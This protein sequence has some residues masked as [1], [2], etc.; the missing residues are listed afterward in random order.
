[1][2]ALTSG[3][4]E[5]SCSSNAMGSQKFIC[6][7][8]DTQRELQSGCADI[9]TRHCAAGVLQLLF[10]TDAST[11]EMST[12][13]AGRPDARIRVIGSRLSSSMQIFPSSVAAFVQSLDRL[14]SARIDRAA[15]APPTAC[16][17]RITSCTAHVLNYLEPCQKQVNN[18]STCE[19]VCVATS[20]LEAK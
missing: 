6:C 14:S 18:I 20:V 2:C 17:E 9:N 16:R 4:W 8:A 3:S 12:A 15:C 19:G 7:T 10:E 1:M 5:R 11:A 13:A